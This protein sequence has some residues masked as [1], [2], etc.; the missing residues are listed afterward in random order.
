M[1]RL[2]LS[3]FQHQIKLLY[4][5]ICIHIMRVVVYR[6]FVGHEYSISVFS[7]Q[8]NRVGLKGRYFSSLSFFWIDR[9]SFSSSLCIWVASFLWQQNKVIIKAKVVF[10]GHLTKMAVSIFLVSLFVLFVTYVDFLSCQEAHW[11][12]YTLPNTK[13]FTGS[14]ARIVSLFQ[15]A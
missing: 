5:K 1:K 3:Y 15:L 6:F 10:G 9:Q 8:H 4:Y 11:E 7:A 2:N 13:F 12:F 14:S